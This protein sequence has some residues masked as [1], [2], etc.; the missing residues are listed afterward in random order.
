M[1]SIPAIWILEAFDRDWFDA[2]QPPS[3]PDGL[4][5]YYSRAELYVLEL[6]IE[7]VKVWPVSRLGAI[8]TSD[9]DNAEPDIGS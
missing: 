7:S 4:E 6:R 2:N 1:S 8:H 3:S 9:V 5:D